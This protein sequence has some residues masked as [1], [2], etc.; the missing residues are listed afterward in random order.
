MVQSINVNLIARVSAPQ[1][2]ANH[3]FYVPSKNYQRKKVKE[4]CFLYIFMT[5]R[6]GFF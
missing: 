3:S 6:A 4:I 2:I 1:M 5:L